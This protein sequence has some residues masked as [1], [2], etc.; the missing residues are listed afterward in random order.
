MAHMN[1]EKKKTLLP[2]IKKVLKKYGVKATVAVR[3]HSTLVLNVSAGPIDFLADYNRTMKENNERNGWDYTPETKGF[4]V[5]TYH[6]ESTYTGEARDFLVEVYAAMMAG[7]H[8]RSDIMTD[9]FDVGWYT[10]INIGKWNK[11][12][13]LIEKK[14][15][16]EAPATSFPGAGI[17]MALF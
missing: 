6:I 13:V 10:D 12:Y 15:K 14:K 9:Y 5:N 17:P 8:D 7:N 11:P 1:Q 16:K 2:G 3:H 4:T